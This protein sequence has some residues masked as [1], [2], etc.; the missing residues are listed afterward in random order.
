MYRAKYRVMVCTRIRRKSRL[1]KCSNAQ[2]CIESMWQ[3]EVD[4]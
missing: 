1:G 2:E 3:E 4:G